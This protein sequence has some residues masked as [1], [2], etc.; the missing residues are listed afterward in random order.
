M[1]TRLHRAA[2]LILGPLAFVA[3]GL[4][5][6]RADTFVPL[7]LSIQRTQ[8]SLPSSLAVPAD[9]IARG[10][11]LVSIYAEHDRLFDPQTGLLT[12]LRRR[13]REW[14][15]PAM[16]SYF[17]QSRLQFAGDVGFRVHGSNSGP[18]PQDQSFRLHFRR[19]YGSEQ[20]MPGVL[21]DGVSDPITR[22]VIQNDR[23]LDGE[24]RWWQFASPLAYDIAG[25]AGAVTPRTQPVRLFINGEFIGI[26]A[27]TEHVRQPFL[28]RRFGHANFILPDALMEDALRRA[29]GEIAPLTMASAGRLLDIESLTRWFVSVVFCATTDPFQAVVLRDATQPDSR[30]FWIA[31]DMDK[32]FMD[33]EGQTTVLSRH[34]TF[35]TT[36]NQPALESKILTRL[37][38]EDPDYRGYLARIVTETLNHRLT[39]EFLS[40]RFAH[41]EAIASRLGVGNRAFL[42]D[43]QFF[44]LLRPHEVRTLVTRHLGIGPAHQVRL[45]GPDAATFELDGRRV[46]S[47]FT[48]WYFEGTEVT[49]A[50][51]TPSRGFSHWLV[52]DRPVRTAVLAHPITEDIVVTP[53]F[54]ATN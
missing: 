50:L 13:G 36:L 4:V 42:E 24:G 33:V 51:A 44:L 40:E 11:P 23:H 21:F 28:S 7:K 35:A 46:S 31:W 15:V 12:N 34:D 16:V 18:T 26:Y 29:I 1:I 25:Q 14:E 22:L 27:L 10:T 6:E 9:E 49:L 5:L 37:I 3:A 8:A 47:G 32:S 38:D 52:N 20:F 48:G 54:P 41:Y 53:V 30:W 39:P 45:A 43:L 2:L 17:D 19:T